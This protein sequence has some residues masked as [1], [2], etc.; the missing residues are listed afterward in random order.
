LAASFNESCDGASWAEITGRRLNSLTV[1]E[2]GKEFLV[3]ELKRGRASD[4]VVGQMLRY[5]SLVSDELATSGQSV[6]GVIIALKDDQ[7]IRHAL[8]ASQANIQ[9]LRYEVK[10]NLISN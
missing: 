4:Y 3:I 7:N 8:K 5:M 1:T 9:F 10:F 2:D 6:R